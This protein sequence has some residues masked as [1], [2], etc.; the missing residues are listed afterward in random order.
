MSNY[1]EIAFEDFIE[2]QLSERHGYRKRVSRTDYDKKLAMDG[3]LALKFLRQSQPDKLDAHSERFGD[4]A[5]PKLLT[6][7][8]SEI[9][10]RGVLDVLRNGFEDR[11]TKFDMAYFQSD[12]SFNA[13]I[14]R[15]YESNILSVI[16]QLKY[17]EK[18]ENS[19]DMVLFVN[20]LPVFTVELKESDERPRRAEFYAAV[21]KRPRPERKATQQHALPR[22]LF[23][24]YRP[25]V[26]DHQAGSACHA[27]SAV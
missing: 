17:S 5:E 7:L 13:E 23:G 1:K 14:E 16:R 12:A 6:R 8:D 25:R 15:L 26:H 27:L 19:I 18:N 9:G 20:G 11:G 24:R 3:E 22:P 4:D 2:Q 10:A 21:Q